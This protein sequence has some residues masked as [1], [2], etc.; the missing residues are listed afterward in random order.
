MEKLDFNRTNHGFWRLIVGIA[1]VSSLV[2]GYNVL[3]HIGW[4]NGVSLHMGLEIAAAG[5]VVIVFLY[6]LFAISRLMADHREEVTLAENSEKLAF[7]ELTSHLE[8]LGEHAITATTSTAGTIIQ[9]N[10]KFGEISGYSIDELIGQ[11]HRVL[12]SRHH[13]TAFFKEMYK[14]IANGKTWSGEIKNRAKDGSFYWVDTTISPLKDRSGK[15]DR[16][17]AIRTVC[18]SR[19]N[20]EEALRR[21]LNILNI[22]FKNF[23]SGISVFTKDLKLQSANP[24]FFKLLD[25]PENRFPI[26]TAY[27]DFIRYNAERGEYGEGDVETQVGD[28]VELAL[29]FEQHS[30]KRALLD[31]GHLEIRGWPIPEGGFITT[32]MDVTEVNNM[33]AEVSTQNERFNAALDNMSQGLSMF[34]CE[35]RLIVANKHYGEMYRLP[36]ELMRTGTTLRQMLEHRIALGF[37]TGDNPEAYIKERH[38]W[39]SSGTRSSKIQLL[40]DGRLIL[41]SHTPMPG[42][43]WLTLHEDVTERKK[44]EAATQRLAKIVEHS[45]N[46]VFIFDSETFKFLQAN[47]S[48]CKNLGYTNEEMLEQTPVDLKPEFSIEQFEELLKP[49]RRGEKDYFRFQTAHRRKDGS[50][51][52]ADIILQEI[53]SENPPVFTAIIDDISERKKAKEILTAHRDQLQDMVHIATQELKIKAEKLAKS[54]SKEKELNELQ[55]QFVSMASHEFRTPLTKMI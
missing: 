46:E 42:N 50:Y 33:I 21:N 11:N 27:A 53:Q 29:K 6:C 19:K 38:K 17:I 12:N 24:A 30:F 40:R 45:I 5:L 47:E 36:A 41:I 35:H 9:A 23:P 54:L 26:G 18:T 10:A 15:I 44:A 14:T 55:R 28:R 16:Y 2:L 39:V 8:A 49:L 25:F 3:S 37:Y 52:D 31:G 34:D 43:G 48:A 20:S 32:Y 7:K 13:P 51:Y 4:G 22:T 1:L